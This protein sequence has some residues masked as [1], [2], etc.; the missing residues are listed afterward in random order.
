MAKNNSFLPEDYLDQK[1]AR[2]TNLICVSLFLVM[3]VSISAAY[4]VQSRQGQ[5][6]LDHHAQVNAK[7][8]ERAEQLK[9]IA[10]LQDRKGEMMGKAKVVQQLV[11]RVPRSI[12]LAEMIISMP[13]SMSLIEFN[14]DSKIVKPGTRPQTSIDRDRQQRN[15]LAREESEQVEIAPREVTIEIVGLT[16][17]DPDVSTFMENLA[18]NPLFNDVGLVYTEQTQVENTNMRRFRVTMTLNTDLVF[19]Q[20]DTEEIHRELGQNPMAETLEFNGSGDGRSLS[21]VPTPT[22]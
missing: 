16:P 13:P 14:L 12:I 5:T 10:Q 9:L 1:I 7:F 17:E 8:A 6:T 22:E 19:D 11:E 20:H 15:Q 21:N 3:I 4:Y 18:G 2:R